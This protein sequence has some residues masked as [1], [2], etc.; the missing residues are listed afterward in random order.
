MLCECLECVKWNYWKFSMVN[1]YLND[2][3]IHLVLKRLTWWSNNLRGWEEL[4][5]LG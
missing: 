1:C 5:V 3:I 4:Y 2:G